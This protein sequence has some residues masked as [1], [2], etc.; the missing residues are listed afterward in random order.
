VR[1]LPALAALVLGA[2]PVVAQDAAAPRDTLDLSKVTI[3]S[4][5]VTG[6][7]IDDPLANALVYVPGETFTAVTDSSGRYALPLPDGLWIVSVFHPRAAE[8]GLERPPTSLVTAQMGLDVR[9]DFTLSAPSLGTQG[10]PYALDAMEVVVGGFSTERSLR[11]GARMD[12]LDLKVLEDR[13]PTARHVG[14]LIQ[15]QFVG[16]RVQRL[17]SS[18]LCIEAPRAAMVRSLGGSVP[19]SGRVAVVLDDILLDDPGGWLIGL[20]PDAIV[21]VEFLSAFDATTRYGEFAAN[22]V[23]FI[24]TY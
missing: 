16:V 2:A 17:N 4:G 14:D 15:G 10:R 11:T 12:V 21:R 22:G 1:A 24:Y 5:I 8:M 19:C 13:R 3:V 6:S 7:G 23:L 20:A 18:D 9:L